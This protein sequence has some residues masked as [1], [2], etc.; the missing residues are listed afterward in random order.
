MITRRDVFALLAGG[1]VAASGLILPTRSIFLPPHGG[2]VVA[3]KRMVI[4]SQY[5]H[6]W[7][8]EL[9]SGVVTVDANAPDYLQLWTSVPLESQPLRDWR[10]FIADWRKER[11]EN[12]DWVRHREAP[13]VES[14]AK[15]ETQSSAD[16][17]AKGFKYS[18]SDMSS[19]SNSISAA[20]ASRRAA[21]IR[22]RMNTPLPR[23]SF[24]E[25][26][27][28]RREFLA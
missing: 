6:I 8:H 25:Y 11:G 19:A 1:T 23:K 22:E 12:Y 26:M 15:V 16:S 13:K 20:A 17:I 14:D 2:W 10:Q 4:E 7:Q 9:D 27:A 5:A 3:Q 18:G 24:E 21:E 28:E